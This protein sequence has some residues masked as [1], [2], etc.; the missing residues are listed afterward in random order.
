M[1]QKDL[2]EIS[3]ERDQLTYHVEELSKVRINLDKRLNS[4]QDALTEARVVAARAERLMN[5]EERVIKLDQE[6]TELMVKLA[7]REAHIAEL[8]RVKVDS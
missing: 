5:S 2:A 6:R 7:E 8:L 1:A 4:A 3:T